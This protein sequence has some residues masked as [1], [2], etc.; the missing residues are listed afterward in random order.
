MRRRAQFFLFIFT[1]PGV[2][3]LVHPCT[4]I[5]AVDTV[6]SYIHPKNIHSLVHISFILH[7]LHSVLFFFAL[8]KPRLIYAMWYVWP[9]AADQCQAVRSGTEARSPGAQWSQGEH[10]FPNSSEV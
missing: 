3:L 6:I 9:A 7:S 4:P 1:E 5:D 10:G 8:V 2:H